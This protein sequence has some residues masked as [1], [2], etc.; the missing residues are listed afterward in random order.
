MIIKEN[1]NKLIPK[2]I[3][4]LFAILVLLPIV[5][6]IISSF[7][8]SYEI[9]KTPFDIPKNLTL[10]NYRIVFNMTGFKETLMN[11]FLI[12]FLTTVLVF[13]ISLPMSYCLSRYSFSGKELLKTFSLF[14]AYLFAPAIL[15]FPYFSLLTSFDIIN[16]RWGIVLA[17]IGFCLPFS[18]SVGDLIFR[19]IPREIEEIAIIQKID[20]ISR[21]S[22][23][24]IPS[25]YP[26]IIALV[27]IVFA[28]SWKE[29]FFA[30]V[31]SLDDSSRTLS[32]FLAN[33][34]N[35]ESMNW[36]IICAISSIMI[37]PSL[38]VL[39]I[40]KK[41]SF[42]KILLSGTKG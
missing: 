32:V 14:G 31:L 8:P 40:G 22:K 36:N 13:V 37:I 29:Y 1:L 16:S 15:A 2:T 6:L 20:I 17:H 33:L 7:R 30:F 25:V 4:T 5:W 24:V 27:L 26:Q 11:S 35:G 9:E 10:E 18:F 21:L 23:I 41:I 39:I 28:I 19:S 12:S 42:V 38:I 3:V 34:Y